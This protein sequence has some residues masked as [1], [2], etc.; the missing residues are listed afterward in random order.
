MGWVSPS[1]LCPRNRR[2]NSLI[3]ILATF[4]ARLPTRGRLPVG[5]GESWEG[6]RIK[7]S[8][9]NLS[10]VRNTDGAGSVDGAE[11]VVCGKG[12]DVLQLIAF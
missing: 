6:R 11:A 1:H 10:N 7:C 4:P 3:S 2:N 8:V 5:E 12:G 9:F